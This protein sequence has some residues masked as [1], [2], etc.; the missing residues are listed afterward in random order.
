[1]YEVTLAS[2][3]CSNEFSAETELD[4]VERHVCRGDLTIGRQLFLIERL[5]TRG[6]RPI[7]VACA[8]CCEQQKFVNR[9]SLVALCDGCER[10][11]KWVSRDPGSN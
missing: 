5:A 1:M 2:V 6:K 9:P 10:G 3:S 8:N 4:M 7:S 11:D